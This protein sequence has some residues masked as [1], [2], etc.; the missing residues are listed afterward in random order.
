MKDDADALGWPK[1][2]Y[3]QI[4]RERRWLCSQVPWQWV[5]GSSSI[6]DLYV[7]ETQLRVREVR[8]LSTD[9]VLFKLAR[10]ADINP[11]KRL[12]TTI[13][14]A[15]EEHDLLSQLPGKT[16]SKVRHAVR[17]PDGTSA[18]VDVFSGDLEHLI[19]VE[20]EFETDEA[21]EAYQPPSIVGPE[22]T[23]D[24]RYSGGHLARHGMPS[25]FP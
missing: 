17:C 9:A 7:S 2:K 25:S 18:S 1:L 13:Y 3:A 20:W 4:E 14:L 11:S 24:L 22:V 5:V 15:K 8:D 16:L 23:D 6:S 19:M 10:K 12:I 21:M